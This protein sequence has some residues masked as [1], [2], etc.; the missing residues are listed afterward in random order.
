MSFKISSILLLLRSNKPR[1]LFEMVDMENVTPITLSFSD[2]KII[3]PCPTSR[4]FS[5]ILWSFQFL[6]QFFQLF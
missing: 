1:S 2:L 6:V 3:A 4:R 5:Q